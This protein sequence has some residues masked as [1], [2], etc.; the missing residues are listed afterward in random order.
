METRILHASCVAVQGKGVLIVGASGS[1]KSSLALQLMAYGADLI[2]DDRTIVSCDGQE[3]TATAP[4][5]ISN[6]IEARSIGLL[7]V[8]STSHAKITCVVDMDQVES[9]RLPDARSYS[10]LGCDIPLLFKVENVTFAAAL[11][12]F[13]KAGRQDTA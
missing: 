4:A 13:I 2:A 12:Q 8:R 11:L 5:S 9:Q 1:G 10:L 3:V 6:M 7:N